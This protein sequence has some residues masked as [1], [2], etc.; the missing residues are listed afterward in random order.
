M[1][2]KDVSI[3]IGPGNHDAVR[4]SEPQT[5]LD[6]DLAGSLY[7]L[8]NVTIVGNPAVINIGST[9]NFE[10]FD[11]LMYHGYS[12]D[13]YSESVESIRFS[14]ANVSERTNMVMKFLLQKRHLA[15]THG[16]T[17]FVPDPEKDDLII[18]KVPDFFIS[19]HIHKAD[20][21]Q[22]GKVTKIAGSCWQ[23]ITPFQI[24]VGHNPEPGRVPVVNLKTRETKI[25]KFSD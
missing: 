8:K 21:T 14:G 18:D 17:L 25:L 23:S 22:Y 10:G 4:M 16:S 3:I 2:R 15:P 19:G 5:K 6:K 11:F 20:V 1:I 7:A 9:N 12:Y 13:E 24:K